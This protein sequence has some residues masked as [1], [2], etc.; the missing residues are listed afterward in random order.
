MPRLKT[1]KETTV[2]DDNKLDTLENSCG[3][4]NY[5]EECKPEN[6]STISDPNLSQDGNISYFLN[7]ND[8]NTI[9]NSIENDINLLDM[10]KEFEEMEIKQAIND[11]SVGNIEEDLLFAEMQ[12]YTDNFTVKQLMQ[13]C[14]YYGIT[15]DIKT[16]KCKKPEIINYLLMFENTTDNFDLV[17][18]RKQLW[19]YIGELKNDKYMKK[20]V[21][22]D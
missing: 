10:M 9:S 18:K 4:L 8:D 3:I 17:M 11:T 19:Y 22:W 15:K 21:L 1:K 5:L 14:D 12:D 2:I 13:I 16:F 7:E 6:N 20:F